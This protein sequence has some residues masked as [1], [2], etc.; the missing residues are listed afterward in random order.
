SGEGLPTQRLLLCEEGY[1]NRRLFTLRLH[2][3]KIFAHRIRLLRDGE[4]LEGIPTAAGE[5]SERY[6]AEC[7]NDESRQRSETVRRAIDKKAPGVF[8]YHHTVNF[9]YVPGLFVRVSVDYGSTVPLPYPVPWHLTWHWRERQ[10]KTP[11][12]AAARQT[13]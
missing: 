3:C 8:I 12:A 7:Q 2:Q 9:S 6:G 1:T 10:S 5:R 11:L 4:G 13:Q